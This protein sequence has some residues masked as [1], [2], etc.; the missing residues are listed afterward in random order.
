MCVACVLGHVKN[1]PKLS[2]EAGEPTYQ[3]VTCP[4]CLVG[5]WTAVAVAFGEVRSSDR[6]SVLQE[7]D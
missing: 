4:T 5:T 6:V 2:L 3:E 7:K 1:E